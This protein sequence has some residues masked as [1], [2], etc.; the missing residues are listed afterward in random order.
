MASKDRMQ[1]Q[2]RAQQIRTLYGE[3]PECLR[4]KHSYSNNF[5]LNIIVTKHNHI[6]LAQ[7]LNNFSD[8]VMV[9]YTR[10]NAMPPLFWVHT[11]LASLFLFPSCSTASPVETL[12]KRFS[13]R[14]NNFSCKS[15]R[16]PNPVILIHGLTGSYETELAPLGNFLQEHDFCIFSPFYGGYPFLPFVGGLRPLEESAKTVADYIAMVKDKTG[17]SKV[18]LVGHS[19]GALLT[20]YIP[21]FFENISHMAKHLV[22]IAPPTHGSTVAGWYSIFGEAFTSLAKI[23]SPICA[24]CS[25]DEPN[26]VPILKLNDGRPIVQPGNI[27]TIIASRNDESITPTAAAAFVDEKGVTNEYVQDYCPLDPTGHIGEGYDQNV[28]NLVLN[29]LEDQIGRKFDCS[30]GGFPI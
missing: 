2:N 30:V 20:L 9:Y 11:L 6:P 26:S 5:E 3:N 13:P 19:E 4:F 29:S 28:A 10:T 8:E 7:L 25:E 16:H 18:D 23:I 1:A 15:S 21:K 22:A 12:F 27:A 24:F 17:A 14:H